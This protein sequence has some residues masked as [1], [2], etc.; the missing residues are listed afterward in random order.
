MS[1]I[2]TSERYSHFRSGHNSAEDFPHSGCPS[3]S[4]TNENMDEERI[5]TINNVC[6][7]L[8]LLYGTDLRI[9]TEDLNIMGKFVSH[10]PNDQYK[11]KTT[12][13][14]IKPKRTYTLIF[15]VLLFPKMIILIWG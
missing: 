2:L 1:K 14:K 9:L 6:N 13:C 5:C 8:G 10:L 11:N 7:I 3:S 4:H 15:K 12:F